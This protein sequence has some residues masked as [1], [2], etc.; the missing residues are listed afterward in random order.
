MKDED[1]LVLP[2][3]GFRSILSSDMSPEDKEDNIRDFYFACMNT[4][5]IA[6]IKSR[7]DA[8][9]DSRF[10]QPIPY[11][12]ILYYDKH[13]G[14]KV[15]RVDKAKVL[16]YRR[17]V[18]GGE[19][20]LHNTWSVGFGGHINSEDIS[21]A[22]K[23]WPTTN[24]FTICIQRELMEELNMD[25]DLGVSDKVPSIVFYDDSTE[26]SKYH[27]CE[28][29]YFQTTDMN[30]ITA[31]ENSIKELHWMPLRE[32]YENELE[33]MESWSKKVIMH[34]FESLS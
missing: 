5:G 13:A 8:E 31:N 16:V 6:S 2:A 18:E 1:I 12:V 15:R 22:L 20:R 33:N 30:S 23:E 26:V 4:S 9:Q 32:L 19:T 3:E 29:I 10:I 34:M 24:P 11:A 14:G 25:G 17:G 27:I 21:E 7:T 28:A